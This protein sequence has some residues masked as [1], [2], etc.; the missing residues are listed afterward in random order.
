VKFSRPQIHAVILIIIALA[1][2]SNTFHV[3]F[4]LDDESSIQLH[5]H[6]H[7]LANYFRD[8]AGYNYLPNRAFGYLTFALNYEF[9]Q[10]NVQ[11]YHLVNLAIHII[12]A[13]LVYD[14]VNLTFRTTT[15][16][17]AENKP[18]HGRIFA[19]VVALLFVSHPIQTQAVTYITQRLTSLSTML[20]LA[21]LVCYLRWRLRQT[22]ITPA[23][24]RIGLWWYCLALISAIL[25]MKTKEIAVTLPMVVLLIECSFFGIPKWKLLAKLSPLLMTLAIIPVTTVLKFDPIV[26]SVGGGI[27]AYLSDTQSNPYDI[28]RMTRWEYLF[29]QFNV[30]CTYLRLLFLPVN[31]H[32]DYDYPINQTL[33]APRALMALTLLLTILAA[34]VIMFVKSRHTALLAPPDPAGTVNPLFTTATLL[35]LAAF[36]IFWF[37]IT[38]SVESSIIAIRDV[39]YE[40]RL[41]LPSYGFFL[42]I[43]ALATIMLNKVASI[44]PKVRQLTFI[45]VTGII[46]ALSIA[47]YNRNAV[48][49][50]WITLWTDNVSKSPNKPRP[51]NILGI[52]YFYL[53]NFDAAMQEYQKAIQLKPDFIE[54]YYNIGLVH[55]ARKEFNEAIVMYLKVLGMSANNELENAKVHNEIGINYAELGDIE[56]A[57]NAFAAA[58]KNNP[59]L[60]EY[61]VNYAFALSNAGNIDEAVL[62]YRQALQLDPGN[63]FALNALEDI[64]R[65]TNRIGQNKKPF[66]GNVPK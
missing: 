26:K 40:H 22:D 13:L 52:G 16:N 54:A 45:A 61:R 51:H 56:Q 44:S 66:A 31:Q 55:N 20:Y 50:D 47:T 8:W 59:E 32:I 53:E 57:T 46:V 25:A 23:K 10:L 60:A 21:A 30:I 38:L 1:C 27:G 28:V 62:Q 11:G 49:R 3:P 37:F 34:A 29:T 43:T 6:V 48:W 15:L 33:L 42:T 35:R 24:R 18:S 2:Y 7:G 41:Y 4:I 58:V 5:T 64:K 63:S 17:L 12:T 36:G 19:F 9:G 39:I 65:R 14:L